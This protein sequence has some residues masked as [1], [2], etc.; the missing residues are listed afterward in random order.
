MLTRHM[1]ELMM[2][3]ERVADIGC[4]EIRANELLLWYG[5]D[6][7]TKTIWSDLHE[8][9]EEVCD[10]SPLL[11]GDSAGIWVLAYGEGLKTSA[12]AWFKD[13]RALAGISYDEGVSSLS[14]AA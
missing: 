8:K 7:M 4:A 12:D 9:W 10:E 5:R 11:V 6:R 1:N 14:K 13:V 2:R 3:L